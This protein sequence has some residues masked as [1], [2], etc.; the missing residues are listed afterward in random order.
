VLRARML[1]WVQQILAFVTQEVLEPNWRA[2]EAK[3]SKVVTVDQLLRDHVD[4]L[5]TCMKE[6]M[7]TSSKLLNVCKSHDFLSPSICEENPNF[8]TWLA[9][10]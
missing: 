3:L 7:L 9:T 10:Q 4:F 8:L 6:C 5:D 2:L 1:A